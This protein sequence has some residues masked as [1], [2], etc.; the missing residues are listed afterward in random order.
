VQNLVGYINLKAAAFEDRK[1]LV[2]H[3]ANQDLKGQ[4]R[5][6]SFGTS[7]F[8]FVTIVVLTTRRFFSTSQRSLKLRSLYK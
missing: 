5:R 4:A 2:Y 8:R 1:G 7:T 6:A 3:E